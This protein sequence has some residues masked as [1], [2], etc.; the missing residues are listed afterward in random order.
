MAI[1]KGQVGFLFG[2]RCHGAIKS[3]VQ[4]II[5]HKDPPCFIFGCNKMVA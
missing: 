2:T 5:A 1:T 4:A 3:I